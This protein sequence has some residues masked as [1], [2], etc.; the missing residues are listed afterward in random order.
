MEAVM[1][2]ARMNLLLSPQEKSSIEARA[3]AANMNTSEFMRAAVA[4]YDPTVDTEELAVLVG[5]LNSSADR[6]KGQLQ[7]AVAKVEKL[8]MELADK[9]ALRA[10][11][12]A[13]LA[14]SGFIW[15]ESMGI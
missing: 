5:E 10:A 2:T 3:R 11:A 12:R 14:Q 8:E 7:K 6:M 9:S 4:Q 13:E 15:P 1:K